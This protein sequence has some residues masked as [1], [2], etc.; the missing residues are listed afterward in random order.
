MVRCELFVVR[1]CPLI[2][3]RRSVL[4]AMLCWFCG[5]LFLVVCCLSCVVRCE[6]FVVCRVPCVVCCR[7]CVVRC[8]SSFAIAVC[9]YLMHDVYCRVC[10]LCV[11]CGCALSDVCC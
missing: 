8:V 2:G 10:R 6:L 1:S 5:L 3:V 4:F 7:L 9:C 11:I